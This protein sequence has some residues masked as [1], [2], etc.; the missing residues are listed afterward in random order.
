[1]TLNDF[2]RVMRRIIGARHCGGRRKEL[3]GKC[4]LEYGIPDVEALSA[5]RR[6]AAEDAIDLH[7][8]FGARRDRLIN[9]RT[10]ALH[11]ERHRARG[12]Q[13]SCSAKELDRFL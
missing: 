3:C 6:L 2:S 8:S 5:M 9:R 12:L 1:M 7:L 11:D 13:F 10:G 4:G